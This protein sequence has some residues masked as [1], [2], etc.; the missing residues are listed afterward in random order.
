MSTQPGF[1]ERDNTH[2]QT[3]H[4]RAILVDMRLGVCSH[5]HVTLATNSESAIVRLLT[6]G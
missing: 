2:P 5:G 3:K 6:S 1:T 4:Q